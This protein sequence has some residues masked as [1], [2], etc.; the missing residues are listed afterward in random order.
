MYIVTRMYVVLY[1]SLASCF[2]IKPCRPC[3]NG[4]KKGA[5]G[6]FL[7][8]TRCG[9]RLVFSHQSKVM[10]NQAKLGC[11]LGSKG[12]KMISESQGK[13]RKVKSLT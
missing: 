4:Q 2:C 1:T 9:P 10:L 5:S 11:I 8:A 6:L 3:M 12:L 7:H 13:C